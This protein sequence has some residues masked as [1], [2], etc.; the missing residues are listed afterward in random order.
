MNKKR[1]AAN[2]RSCCTTTNIAYFLSKQKKRQNADIETQ[3][4]TSLFFCENNEIH[5]NIGC[6]TDTNGL[7]S[8]GV[9]ARGT[10]CGNLKVCV[11]CHWAKTDIVKNIKNKTK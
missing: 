10:F 11:G 2:K 1:P 8:C 3:L 5:K 7:A 6:A 9:S 4:L